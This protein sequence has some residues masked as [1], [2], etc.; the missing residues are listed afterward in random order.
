MISPVQVVKRQL[1]LATHRIHTLPVVILLLHSRCSCRCIMCDMWKAGRDGPELTVEQLADQM[2]AFDRFGV[3][4]VVLSGGEPLLHSDLWAVCELLRTHGIPSITL[5]TAG[6]ALAPHREQVARWCDDVIVSLDGSPRVHDAIRNVPRAYE[7]LAEGIAALKASAPHLRVTARCT[8]QRANHTDLSGVVEAAHEL[9]LDG[10]SFVAA[11]VS[12]TA[13][14]RSASW[15]EERVREVAPGPAEV[16]E[17]GQG[18]EALVRERA[19]DFRSGFVAESPEKLRRLVRYMA[20]LKG[21]G[22]FPP[23]AC[24]APWVSTVI[25]ADGTVRPCFFHPGLGNIQERSL[26]RILNAPR[27]VAFRRGLDVTRDAVCR[28]CVC[29]LYLGPRGKV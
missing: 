2:A 13:F 5:L 26:I 25:E 22:D 21:E 7:R 6:L 16:A 9:G 8:V 28:R 20:A 10:I 18:V 27:S 11:D 17:L 14:N 4:R 29:T 24:N 3:R 19:E 1:T 23:T 15:G 12:T